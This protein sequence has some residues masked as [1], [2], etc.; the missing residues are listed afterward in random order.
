MA[1]PR[2]I[3]NDAESV[4]P[5]PVECSQLYSPNYSYEVAPTEEIAARAANAVA[6]HRRYNLG[7]RMSDLFKDEKQTEL[8]GTEG[9]REVLLK[10]IT[11][12]DDFLKE[13]R[14]ILSIVGIGGLGKTTIAQVVYHQLK[15]QFACGAFVRVPL[16]PDMVGFFT[17]MLCQLDVENHMTIKTDDEG[18][19][20]SQIQEFLQGKRYLVVID[21]LWNEDDWHIILSSLPYNYYGSRVITT[22]RVNGIANMCCS[23]FADLIYE[24]KHLGYLES[25]ELFSKRF[26]GYDA[27][28]PNAHTDFLNDILKMCGGTPSAIISI[29]SL[30]ANEVGATKPRLEILNHVY[31]T[32]KRPAG[33]LQSRSDI[34]P[35][36]EVWRDILSLIY[37]HLPSTLKD[38]LLYLAVQAKNQMIHRTTT[39]MKWIAEGFIS[40]CMGYSREEVAS[41]CFDELIDRNFIQLVEY[42]NYPG[43]EIY[44]ANYLMLCALKLISQS[45][46]F[47]TIWHDDKISMEYTSSV[48]LSIQCSDSEYPVQTEAMDR[49]RIRS[50]TIVGPAKL[51]LTDNLAYLRVLDLDGCLG[52][53][54]SAMDYIC[55][56]ILLKYLRLKH[57][58]VTEI[59]PEI[60]K[61]RCLETLDIRHT[62][63]KELTKELYE[64]PKLAHLY[65]DQSSSLRG[66]KL[67]MGSG[68]WESVKA[69]VGTVDSRKW[70]GSAIEEITELTGVT[71]LQV[72]LHDQPADKD[73][74]EKL[75]SSIDDRE[76]LQ[77]LIIHGDY[78]PSGEVIPVSP[79]FPLLE[80]LKVT[81]RFVKVP[82]WL[83]QLSNLKKLDVRVCKLDKDDLKI[84]G[85]LPTLSNLA[86]ALICIPWKK[87]VAIT[88][89]LHS[90]TCT[91][92]PPLEQTCPGGFRSLEVFSFDCRVPWITFE[93]GALPKLKHLHLKLYACPA[94]KLPSGL[95]NLNSLE[96]IILQYPSVYA[97]SRGITK[98]V[99][100]MREE[101]S[102]HCNL[103]GLSVN[104]YHV[105]FLPNTRVD[106][107]LN[108]TEIE[109]AS[110]HRNPI[111]LPVNGDH[112]VLLSNARVAET[113]TGT[114]IEEASNHGNPIKLSVNGNHEVLLPNTRVDE[115]ISCI[116][117]KEC[118]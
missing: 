63:V 33:Y 100:A 19:I 41:R 88:S 109:E 51:Y 112:E 23:G 92:L 68:Q 86:L 102:S 31:C 77:T 116:E 32:W 36:F 1:F 64:L 60:G 35:G 4:V 24:I 96:K 71:E 84:L 113:L 89:S 52:L 12:G 93:Q 28:V 39:V 115:I 94:D 75:L 61:L 11:E 108:G 53:K 78:N 81:G 26:V 7:A 57:T 90:S 34:V 14:K 69:L 67:A 38:C 40:E 106:E 66:E 85:G 82:R 9:P 110:N 27:H 104:G 29:A 59:P 95:K 49:S 73:Q 5:L 22:T 98:V 76:N 21:D 37:L 43:E 55:R 50:I 54:N 56:M 65:Y 17:E 25:R 87:E 13:E 101:A 97:S 91:D 6:V 72:V 2:K 30:L 107:T 74:N 114:A 42:G 46:D 111:E 18:K 47:A 45:E 99:A 16:H 8:V 20:I 80:K 58:Q 118:Y 44:E 15:P 83:A 48:R 70:S 10:M 79:Y 62:Q 105:V 117:I 103:I 3:F